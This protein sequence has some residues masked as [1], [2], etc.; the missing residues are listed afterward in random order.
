MRLQVLLVALLT[1][2]ACVKS[3]APLAPSNGTWRFSGT[4]SALEGGQLGGPIAGAALMVV[5]GVNLYAKVTTDGAG[6]YV[7][8]ALESGRFSVTISAPGFV[9]VTPVVDL[10][11][12]TDVSFGLRRE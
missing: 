11:Q 1:T 7:F 3:S 8:P 2:S 6:R 4:V 5:N 12:D 10:Y 9:S